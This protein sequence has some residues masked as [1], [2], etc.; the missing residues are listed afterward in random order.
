MVELKFLNKNLELV[1]IIDTATSVQW[2]ERFNEVGTFEIYVQIDDYVKDILL[3]SFF[4]MRNDSERIGVIRYFDKLTSVE[5]GDYVTIIGKFA[6]DLIGQRI[7]RY[8]RNFI[9]YSRGDI[10]INLLN[11]NLLNPP[12]NDGE[13]VSPRKMSLFDTTINDFLDDSE[14]IS[15]QPNYEETDNLLEYILQLL[16]EI[17]SSIKVT[18]ND[19][20]KLQIT[21][22][23]GIDRSISQTENSFVLFSKNFDNLISS[24]FTRDATEQKNV[25]Y[26]GGED[27]DTRTEGRIIVKYDRN[28]DDEIISDLDRVEVYIDASDIEQQSTDEWN[29]LQPKLTDAEY[30]QLLINRA[31]ENVIQPS[32]TLEAIVDTSLYKYGSNKDYYLGDMVTIEDEI[33]G[34]YNKTIIGMDFV[35][36]EISTMEPIFDDKIVKAEVAIP[37]SY[38]LTEQ[39]EILLTENNLALAP[40]T[41]T[42]YSMRSVSTEGSIKISELPEVEQLQEGCCLPVVSNGE[43]KKIYYGNLQKD[44]ASKTYVDALFE[45]LHSNLVLKFYCIEQVT[46]VVNGV[47]TI[48]P[49]NSNVEIPLANTDTFEIITTSDK[50]ILSLSGFPGAISTYYNWLEGVQQFS[51]VIFNMTDVSMYEKWNQGHQGEYNVQYAQYVNCIFWNDNPY[52]HGTSVATRTN[53]T[54]YS[55]SQ[56]PLC[57]ATNPANT[58]KPFYLAYGVQSDPN[59][60]NQDYIDSYSLVTNATQ[61]FS[62]YGARTIGVFNMEVR[63]IPLPK[64]CRGLM[65]YSWTIENAGVFDATK[66]TSAN[67]FGAKRGSWQEAFGYCYNLKRLYITNL[68]SNLNLSWSPIERASINFIINN[69]AATKDLKIWVSPV[70]YNLLTTDDIANATSKRISI[71][72]ETANYSEDA[73]INAITLTGDG[74]QVLANNGKYIPLPSGGSIEE[75]T[76]S[77]YVDAGGEFEIDVSNAKDYKL[78]ISTYQGGDSMSLLLTITFTSGGVANIT[79]P[80]YADDISNSAYNYIERVSKVAFRAGYMHDC[81]IFNGNIA[82]INIQ[83]TDTNDS[84]IYELYGTILR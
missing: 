54:L 52:I 57:Y 14:H 56:L 72:L 1:G 46:I 78:Y 22:F 62:Y 80:L 47:P 31:K 84:G 51:N 83:P 69:S 6:E 15:A 17:N 70:T 48:Y 40:E 32:E 2:K 64:D 5:E 10:I 27:D 11:D 76:I 33:F 41:A 63:P 30:R 79:V 82:T 21:L 59:W 74:T 29:I 4:V 77:A 44:F 9:S 71:I 19:S 8:R 23:N 34:R 20:N 45:K 42:T 65:F 39:N 16:N 36:E 61:T 28:S 25:V 67:N 18:L 50:S 66:V 43:T 13:T 68:N 12:L 24:N 49:E 75:E 26:A 55:S 3:N 58:Y 73:R 81:C 60:S 37:E 38:L 35:D 53:Y 7:I